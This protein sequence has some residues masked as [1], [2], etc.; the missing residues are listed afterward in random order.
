MSNRLG[1]RLLRSTWTLSPAGRAEPSSPTPL[2]KSVTPKHT[3]TL[4][5]WSIVV[6]GL[7]PLW[8]ALVMNTLNTSLQSWETDFFKRVDRC[9]TVWLDCLTYSCHHLSSQV[10]QRLLIIRPRV[11][12]GFHDHLL[13]MFV[14]T[15]TKTLKSRSRQ[16]KKTEATPRRA[17]WWDWQHFRLRAS[18]S[19]FWLRLRI[20]VGSPV[21]G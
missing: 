20:D 3:R 19:A 2:G 21:F 14:S 5:G 16:W 11:G 1:R 9:Q 13:Q 4:Q 7:A 10:L 15:N 8:A 6:S 12:N 18:N 17:L